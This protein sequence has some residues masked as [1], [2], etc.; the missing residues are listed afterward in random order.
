[1]AEGATESPP[2]GF[3]NVVTDIDDEQTGYTVNFSATERD[4]PEA[5]VQ[6]E[7]N[8]IEKREE[9]AEAKVRR[10]NSHVT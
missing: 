3:D 4:S 5:A 2:L 8:L 10:L 7:I 6:E 1:M 9:S